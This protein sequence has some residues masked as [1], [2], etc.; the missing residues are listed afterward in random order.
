MVISWMTTGTIDAPTVRYYSNPNN[1]LSSVGESATYNSTT[2]YVHHTLLKHLVLDTVYYYQTRAINSGWSAWYNF[3][4]P[5]ITFTGPFQIPLYG[6]M[7]IL[8]SANSIKQVQSLVTKDRAG[9]LTER[10]PF[11]LHV[12][13]ISYADDRKSEEYESVWNKWFEMMVGIHR[14]MP[15]M[16]LPGN[17]EYSSGAPTLPYSE[18]FVDYNYRFKMPL[19]GPINKTDYYGNTH[20]MWWSFDHQNVHFIALSTETDFTKS[21]FDEKFGNQLDWLKQDLIAASK[22]R[23]KVPWIIAMG[24]RPLYSSACCGYIQDMLPPVQGAYEELFHEYGVDIFFCGHVHAY[25]RTWPVYRNK[26][27]QKNYDNPSAVVVITSGAAGDIEGLSTDW[28][29]PI[30]DWSAIRYSQDESYGVIHIVSNTELR[31][32][33][34]ESTRNTKVDEMILTKKH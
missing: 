16:V 20:N 12:G 23:A 9:Q 19:A 13:D 7:G 25:E 26:T 14:Y 15:Y 21:P 5:N 10:V 31:W 4:T 30:P 2:G 1:I 33:V 32:E 27:V 28:I 18:Y 8:N 34:Y 3:V 29:K 6:D 22:N 11:I 24:H 17:H